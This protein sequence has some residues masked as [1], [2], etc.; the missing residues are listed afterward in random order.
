MKL[1]SSNASA[2]FTSLPNG[3]TNHSQQSP[4]PFKEIKHRHYLT[5]LTP[6]FNLSCGRKIVSLIGVNVVRAL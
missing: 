1:R 5:F 2:D 3:N 4:L 6:K